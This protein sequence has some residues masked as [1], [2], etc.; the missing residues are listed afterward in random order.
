VGTRFEIVLGDHLAEKHCVV[1][2]IKE[3]YSIVAEMEF[4][5]S[6]SEEN[7][8]Y[9]LGF[10]KV[11]FLAAIT[12]LEVGGLSSNGRIRNSHN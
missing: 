1:G 10:Y 4:H 12:N 3:H 6:N 11:K 8:D 7:E 9:T 5:R 2:T